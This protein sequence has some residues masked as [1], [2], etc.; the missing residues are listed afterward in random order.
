MLCYYLE[1]GIPAEYI[2]SLPPTS[3]M[4]YMASMMK[5]QE[6]YEKAAENVESKRA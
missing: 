6:E 5:V 1:K 4:F 2:L 3:R